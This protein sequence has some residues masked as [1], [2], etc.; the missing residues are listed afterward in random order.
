MSYTHIYN[1]FWSMSPPRLRLEPLFFPVYPSDF[2]VFFGL[3]A[4][5]SACVCDPLTLVRVVVRARTKGCWLEPGQLPRLTDS[6]L[7][8]TAP[9]LMSLSF[10][11]QNRYWFAVTLEAG[12]GDSWYHQLLVSSA[13][14]PCCP[15]G[16]GAGGK[17]TSAISQVGGVTD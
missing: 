8:G 9:P 6:P 4:C 5:L 14:L 3:L 10:K 7:E 2:H 16:P 15:R 1:V 17:D 11:E 12:I 13:C